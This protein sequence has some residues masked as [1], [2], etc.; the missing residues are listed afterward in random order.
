MA[1][2]KRHLRR[3]P[4]K[5]QIVSAPLTPNKGDEIAFAQRLRAE[6]RR[7]CK[8][9]LYG[10]LDA[11]VN[12]TP[13]MAVDNLRKMESENI[14]DISAFAETFAAE[15]VKKEYRTVNYQ[16]RKV[17]EKV[18]ETISETENT[19]NAK[20]SFELPGKFYTPQV[21]EA[22]EASVLETVSLI[23][24]IPRHYH[25]RIEGALLRQMQNGGTNIAQLKK[26]LKEAGDISVRRAGN[27]ALDQT[28][29]TFSAITQSEFRKYGIKKFKWLHIGGTAHPRK[30]HMDDFPKGLNGGIFDLDDPPVIEPK[31]GIKGI[32]AQ[33][34]FCRC[35]MCAVID[36][37]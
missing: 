28:R 15:M 16:M 12:I 13:Q 4:P 33:L 7:M 26:E 20:F 14:A 8:K 3:K 9:T 24:S 37:E 25:L 36:E 1:D 11:D 32:P 23:K 5:K 22:V 19:F 2:K 17:V 27:I 29:K 30:Y 35:V 6:V 31:T 10:I 18:A 34:P 21:E